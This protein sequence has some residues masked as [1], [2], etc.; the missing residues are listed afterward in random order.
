MPTLPEN[1]KGVADQRLTAGSAA[2]ASAD[3]KTVE[4]HVSKKDDSS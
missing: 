2:K 1:L 3:N 4:M